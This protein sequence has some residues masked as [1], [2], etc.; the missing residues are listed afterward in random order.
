M[1]TL[2]DLLTD[3]R[4]KYHQLLTGTLARVYVDQNGERVE[5]TATNRQAL[6]AYITELEAAIASGGSVDNGPIRPVFF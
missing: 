3:A 2:S 1:A 4:A 5:Y 6:K